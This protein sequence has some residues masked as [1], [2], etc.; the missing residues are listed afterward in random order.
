MTSVTAV[1]RDGVSCLSTFFMWTAREIKGFRSRSYFKTPQHNLKELLLASCQK[2]SPLISV[3]GFHLCSLFVG[4][5]DQKNFFCNNLD[6]D[7][8]H[9]IIPLRLKTRFSVS[10]SFLPF[11]HPQE[12]A[13][14][15]LKTCWVSKKILWTNKIMSKESEPEEDPDTGVL[16]ILMGDTISNNNTV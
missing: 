16:L 12:N 13:V 3:Q 14:L 10:F 5:Q 8:F 4:T 15:F 7:F 2:S 9:S 1:S 6:F 11:E